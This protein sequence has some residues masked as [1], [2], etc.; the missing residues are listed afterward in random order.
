[1][2]DCGGLNARLIKIANASFK[3]KLHHQLS[4]IGWSFQCSLYNRMI[5]MSETFLGGYLVFTIQFASTNLL[6]QAS[7]HLLST[8][9]AF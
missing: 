3:V 9:I 5:E 1:M 6:S 7:A 4:D 8:R 2:W